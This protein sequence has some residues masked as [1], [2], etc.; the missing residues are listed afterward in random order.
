MFRAI[1]FDLDHT[2]FDRYATLRA[3]L[4]AFYDHYRD[5][6][7]K[8]LSVEEFIEKFIEI[9]QK[10]IHYD[11]IRVIKECANAG[12]ISPMTEDEV[13]EAV[14]VVVNECWPIAAE[15]FP[16]TI[17][18]LLKLKEM[19]Y[20]LGIITNGR[21]EPQVLK[22]KMLDLEDLF[23]EIVISGDIGAQ[24]PSPEPFKAMAEKIGIDPKEML[25]VG[26]HPRNDV[27]G[28]RNAGYIPVWV[29]TIKHWT[30]EE[31]KRADYE[32]DTVAELPELLAKIDK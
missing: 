16:F 28:S 8:D 6:I 32:I 4:H 23:D 31:I 21:H 3:T 25:Y 19:G 9:E 10:Y 26:D 17:P 22:I 18:T 5:I 2:L 15:K 30:F 12:I 7:P 29:K 27:D 1:V 13:K 11:W 14:G 20:K 24:K